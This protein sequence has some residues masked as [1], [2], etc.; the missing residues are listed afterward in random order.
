MGRPG[1]RRFMTSTEKVLTLPEA[2]CDEGYLITAPSYLIDRFTPDC[3]IIHLPRKAV[4]GGEIRA[5]RHETASR[6]PRRSKRQIL[7]RL[8][9]AVR[10][11]PVID[12]PRERCMIDLRQKAAIWNWAHFLDDYLPTAFFLGDLL[13]VGME[14]LAL[15]SSAETP[16]YI[17]QAAALLGLTLLCTDDTLRGEAIEFSFRPGTGLRSVRA[18]WVRTPHVEAALAGLR[19]EAHA[20]ARSGPPRRLFLSRRGTR[21]LENE[22]EI[23]SF[24]AGRGYQK[25]YP[26]TLSAAEQF[27][28]FESAEAI[29]AIHG[30]ALAPLL[31]RSEASPLRQVVELFPCGHMTDVFRVVAG[32]VGCRWAGVRGRIRPEQ[33]APAY[34]FGARFTRF[35]LD[36]FHVDPRS[37]A[38]A[39]EI[40]EEGPQRVFS[41]APD[42]P[43]GHRTGG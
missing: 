35:S 40:C 21:A 23:E 1:V 8:A 17:R 30:A 4:G 38:L 32:Q 41:A 12:L 43:S 20:L 9:A 33:V 37:L 34:D 18:G 5:V 3:E 10:P 39:L 14:R 16:D 42:R 2:V 29:V 31:Y 26:E 13:G 24:L 25:I 22:A 15:V 11:D 7:Q 28:L 27:K 36:P 6:L 19:A